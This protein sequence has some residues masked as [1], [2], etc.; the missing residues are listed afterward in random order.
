MIVPAGK[1]TIYGPSGSGFSPLVRTF[2]PAMLENFTRSESDDFVS[3]LLEQAGIST[4][5]GVLDRIYDVTE[6][7]PFVLSAY[8]HEAYTK[9]SGGNSLKL[10]HLSAV[11]LDFVNIVLAPFFARF[12]DQ[13]GKMS[14]RI[15]SEMARDE[16]GEMS[17]SKL[18]ATLKKESNELSP[19]LA[20]LIQD[21]AIIRMDRGKYKLF[22]HLLGTYIRMR[23]QQQQELR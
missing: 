4:G 3:K 2:A 22:H 18:S 1:L 11:D 13:A 23:V 14:R 15:L 7:H 12:Y 8:M 10:E 21:G 17:L 19:S 16:K 9:I 6:G 20:K 5:T